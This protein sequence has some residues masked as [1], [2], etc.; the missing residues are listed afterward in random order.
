MIFGFL[1]TF[2]KALADVLDE[3]VESRLSANEK[4]GKGSLTGF[5]QVKIATL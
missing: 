3:R 4:A 5:N 2:C 1:V